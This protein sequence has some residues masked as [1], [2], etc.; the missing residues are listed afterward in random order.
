MSK[1]NIRIGAIGAALITPDGLIHPARE[2]DGIEVTAVAARDKQRA[3]SFASEHGI[4]VVHSG[5]QAL[6]DDPDIDAVYIAL[7]NHLHCEWTLRALRAGKHVLCEKPMASNA[8]EAALMQRE[9]EK[10]SLILAEAVHYRYHQLALKVKDIIDSG[11]LGE[12]EHIEARMLVPVA[13]NDIRRT[14]ELAGGATMDP[15]C[16]PLSML[17]YFG[18]ATPEVVDVEM[19]MGPPNVD[20][21][22]RTNVRFPNGTTGVAE[23]RTDYDGLVIELKIRGSKGS[24]EVDNPVLPHL[25]NTLTVEIEGQRSEET[26]EGETTFTA[27]LRAFVAWVKE[28]IPMATD[29][30][31]AVRNMALIDEVYR[32]AGIPV[33]GS[34]SDIGV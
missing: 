12:I 24:I 13:E 9:A 33:R 29:A 32:K 4:P 30:K 26:V 25:W 28:G 2:I 14:F 23:A 21:R 11:K 22:M 5:Y 19:T 27:Q 17:S 16:Y 18:G 8:E 1:G 7:P 6:L 10:C 31:E 15:G 3:Q 20:L 34:K